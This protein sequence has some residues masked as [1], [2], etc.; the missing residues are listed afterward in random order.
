MASLKKNTRV[1][2]LA[3]P[4]LRSELE[5]TDS[6][7]AAF[8]SPPP[9]P[10]RLEIRP[11][12]DSMLFSESFSG[13]TTENSLEDVR[14]LHPLPGLA[15]NSY[16]IDV[17][18]CSWD[19]DVDEIV[20]IS[21][22][23]EEA[24]MDRLP[25]IFEVSDTSSHHCPAGSPQTSV[26]E[27]D[28]LPTP[29]PGPSIFP[30]FFCRRYEEPQRL[31]IV[32]SLPS[33][34]H[35]H[36]CTGS[37]FMGAQSTCPHQN[38]D[39]Y[40]TIDR[41]L[42]NFPYLPIIHGIFRDDVGCRS[43][44][45]VV[46][47]YDP[48]NYSLFE[49]LN[50]GPLDSSVAR[51]WASEIVAAIEALHSVNIVHR[52]LRLEAFTISQS[53]HLILS[54]L[55]HAR[56]SQLEGSPE[57]NSGTPLSKM[58]SRRSLRLRSSFSPG[59][60]PDE[61]NICFAPEILLGWPHDFSVD[62]WG[63]GV[64]LWCMFVDMAPFYT[65]PEENGSLQSAKVIG[66]GDV[67]ELVDF[68]LV[69]CEVLSDLLQKCLERNPALR[70]SIQEV[71]EH[72]FFQ[73]RTCPILSNNI[74]SP[75]SARYVPQAN[76]SRSPANSSSAPLGQQEPFKSCPH[77][78]VY[79]RNPRHHWPLA[80][81]Q[82]IPPLRFQ[83]LQQH[84]SSNTP[85]FSDC[86]SSHRRPLSRALSLPQLQNQSP[87]IPRSHHLSPTSS[88]NTTHPDDILPTPTTLVNTPLPQVSSALTASQEEMTAQERMNMFWDSIDEE[89][90]RRSAKFSSPFFKA[91]RLSDIVIPRPGKH[92]K[93]MKSA[94]RISLKKPGVDQPDLVVMKPYAQATI[95]ASTRS[96]R[97]N[98]RV[99]KSASAPFLLSSTLTTSRSPP[100]CSMT[101][102][103]PLPQGVE[104]IGEGIGFTYR[105][106]H[107][108]HSKPSICTSS[109]T[110]GTMPQ[111]R[112]QFGRLLK[113]VVGRIKLR[114]GGGGSIGRTDW[115]QPSSQCDEDGR[116]LDGGL[117]SG[118][119][120]LTLAAS[121]T[122]V[123]PGKVLQ[124]SEQEGL[125]GGSKSPTLR[126]V[127]SPVLSEPRDDVFGRLHASG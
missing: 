1:S 45:N 31:F 64:V 126:L 69:G 18:E 108:I 22:K 63:I 80:S 83:C 81:R 125:D 67:L 92:L 37:S 38:V 90:R 52:A 99:R 95:D 111:Y 127:I 84:H 26:S 82:P 116:I 94:S 15:D 44:W 8:P 110:L 3:R 56:L 32:K 51:V 2:F 89:E 109:Q 115:L 41:E 117:P 58:K 104:R 4:R 55:A 21:P 114:S 105:L 24:A 74:S 102:A 62:V 34:V 60:T 17:G 118:A 16:N 75:R 57:K 7:L 96:N 93:K 123:E 121:Q 113:R 6:V 78:S 66:N 72:E 59:P 10:P 23:L 49:H 120:A 30:R 11:S 9:S 42:K 100:A 85:L 112:K 47:D 101:F 19:E 71:R 40:K 119:S 54:D 20:V 46:L 107:A 106:E 12:L 124:V 5:E 70:V 68:G 79:S 73:S 33:S 98:L 36:C 14:A 87:L 27:F 97:N 53:G 77:L 88:S 61:G 28:V 103:K 25:T 91:F 29:N 35:C 43:G 39:V 50:Q 122:P 13:L 86:Q 76:D 48:T 65:S